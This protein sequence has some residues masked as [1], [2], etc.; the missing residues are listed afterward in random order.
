ML[1]V[2]VCHQAMNFSTC[3]AGISNTLITVIGLSGEAARSL[4]DAMSGC[5]QE[6]GSPTVFQMSWAAYFGFH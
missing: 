1:S 2:R 6:V 5:R 3:S 4:A